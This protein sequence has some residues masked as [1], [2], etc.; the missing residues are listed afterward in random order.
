MWTAQGLARIERV[1]PYVCCWVYSG[2]AVLTQR[3]TGSDPNQS[4]LSAS[5]NRGSPAS[6]LGSAA[7][8]RESNRTPEIVEECASFLEIREVK[9][10][11]EPVVDGFEKVTSFST[12]A[13]I[14]PEAGEAH[15]GA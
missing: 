1:G 8:P 12:V 10:F 4:K 11:G 15:G 6:A 7:R 5:T 14:V 9:T 2:N 3:L 13:L